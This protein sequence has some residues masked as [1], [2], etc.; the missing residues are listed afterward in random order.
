MYLGT[1]MAATIGWASRLATGMRN[2][3][4]DIGMAVEEW[5]RGQDPSD[6]ALPGATGEFGGATGEWEDVSTAVAA[7]VDDMD[8]LV[9][10]DLAAV[11]AQEKLRK[12]SEAMTKSV[13][14]Q[15]TALQLQADTMG[16]T[17][18]QAALYGL[19]MQATQKGLNGLTLEQL[20]SATA[21]IDSIERQK[22]ALDEFD[23]ALERDAEQQKD[24]TERTRDFSDALAR[25][26]EAAL[27][28]MTVFVDQAARNM[29]DSLADFLF[30]P[31]RD[32]LDGMLQGLI[33]V[34]RRMVAEM[35]A[36]ELFGALSGIGAG[37]GG[38]LGAIGNFFK[39][40]A[41]GG[42]VTAGA[43]YMVGERGPELFIPNHSGSIMPNGAGG[44]QINQ[45]IVVHPGSNAADMYAAAMAGKNAAIAAIDERTRR[46]RGRR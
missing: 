31:F 21:A 39:P 1:A 25:D 36:A 12:A 40:R 10:V 19:Q 27:G 43:P 34:L 4:K 3:G 22:K 7:V 13:N 11:A 17:E 38:V 8:A 28:S 29:Q 42:P 45:Q 15:I 41:D 6:P 9:V 46:T 35:A 2:V 44:V 32:G 14:D 26:S 37:G 24:L 5:T 23:E 20:A 33:D 16:M 18:A 30:D